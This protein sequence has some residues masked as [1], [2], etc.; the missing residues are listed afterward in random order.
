MC[1]VNNLNHKVP[2][3]LSQANPA[4]FLNEMELKLAK[5]R[6]KM[7]DALN[8]TNSSLI[9]ERPNQLKSNCLAVNQFSSSNDHE[10]KWRYVET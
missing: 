2:E 4:N 7:L 8:E 9:D 1:K 3:R 10:R 6:A 5:R